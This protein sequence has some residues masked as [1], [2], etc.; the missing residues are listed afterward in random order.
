MFQSAGKAFINVQ[1][2]ADEVCEV[3]GACFAR[4]A[5]ETHSY[6]KHD[7]A[8]TNIVNYSIMLDSVS[9][10]RTVSLCDTRPAKALIL[11]LTLL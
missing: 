7:Y 5:A 2:K 3:T 4:L 8:K 11:Q 9:E 6:L 1:K 10:T